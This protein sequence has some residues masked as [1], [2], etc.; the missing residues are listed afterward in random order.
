MLKV[1][2]TDADLA[3]V[4]IAEDAD[5]MWELL[6]SSY[7]MRRPEGEPFFGKWRRGS[8]AAVAGSGRLLMSAV[9]PYGYCPDF[10]TPPGARSI[11]DGVLAVL[12]TPER[13]VAADIAELAAQGTRVPP[14]LRGVAEGEQRELHRLG[15]ALHGYYRQCVAPDWASVRH[16]VARERA[17]LRANLDRGGPQLLLSTVHPDVTWTPPVLRVR[18]PVDQELHLDGRGLRLVPSFFAHGMPTTCKDPG[19]PPVL[20]CSI[21]NPRIDSDAEPGAALAALLGHTRARV[22]VTIAAGRCN[23]SELASRAGT[24]LA[25][26]SQH[27]SVLRSSGLITSAR[28]GKA[29]VHEVTPLGQ[30]VIRAS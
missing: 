23:T 25:T 28:V 24:S 21:S 29:Q 7:R 12:A 20:V 6:M 22:L 1:H 27:A 5:P 30:G 17:R 11:A 19:L 13:K 9:P 2:F 16:A 10:L 14:W 4:T 26:A 18:F 15:T 3:K 8:R